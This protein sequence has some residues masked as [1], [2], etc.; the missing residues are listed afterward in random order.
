MEHL[1]FTEFVYSSLGL[2]ALNSKM[3][4]ISAT[5][6]LNDYGINFYATTNRF[7]N[8][9]YAWPFKDCI[10]AFIL[11]MLLHIYYFRVSSFELISDN[12]SGTDLWNTACLHEHEFQCVHV[13]Y[14]CIKFEKIYSALV[15]IYC[16]IFYLLSY[17]KTFPCFFF[18]N[19]EVRNSL[20]PLAFMKKNYQYTKFLPLFLLST[21]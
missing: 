3:R 11:T 6:P 15:A 4:A 16:N 1:H 9:I 18:Q 10:C 8:T 2:K 21:L 5:L 14:C 12:I 20:I 19:T 17:Y 13:I 7:Q